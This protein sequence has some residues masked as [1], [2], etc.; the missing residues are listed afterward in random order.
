MIETLL[1]FLADGGLTQLSWAG[2]V[3]TGLVLNQVTI[4]WVTI[5]LHR[6]QAHRALYPH[7]LVSHFF[8]FWLWLTTGMVTREWV[9]V[10]GKH[11]AKCETPDDPHSPQVLGIRKVLWQGSELYRQEAAN[12][13]TLEH[14]GHL[15]PGD[16]LE[17]R[18]YAVSPGWVSR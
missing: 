14:Y 4:A 17:R 11:H 8:R 18:V 5:Y 3:L 10:I 13:G 6:H 16:W 1:D 9:A 2:V 7:P 12:T 15:T